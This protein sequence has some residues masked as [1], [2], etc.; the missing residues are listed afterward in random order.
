MVFVLMARRPPD[1]TL[2]PYTTLFRSTRIF[3]GCVRPAEEGGETPLVDSRRV[4]EMIDPHIRKRFAEK[5]I[6]YVRN[7][8]ERMGLSWQKVFLTTDRAE[9]ERRCRAARM[10]FEWKSG[11]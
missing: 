6:M 2:F 3:F 4:F 7:Y 11:D 9:V 10:Q 1:C 8:G 5:Q